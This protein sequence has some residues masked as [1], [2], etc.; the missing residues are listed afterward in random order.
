MQNCDLKMVLTFKPPGTHYL[1]IIRMRFHLFTIVPTW[2]W[3]PGQDGRQPCDLMPVLDDAYFFKTFSH[4]ILRIALEISIS[5][6]W[7]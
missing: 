2:P 1:V 3:L 6:K 5:M 4:I 7:T